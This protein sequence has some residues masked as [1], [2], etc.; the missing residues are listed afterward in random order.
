[1]NDVEMRRWLAGL[2][3]VEN[4]AASALRKSLKPV[5][6]SVV[7]YARQQ[8]QAASAR[9][10]PVIAIALDLPRISQEVQSRFTQSAGETEMAEAATAAYL[11]GTRE[12]RKRVSRVIE[13]KAPPVP[14]D[15]VAVGRRTERDKAAA[16]AR[17]WQDEN[18][19]AAARAVTRGLVSDVATSTRMLEIG[20]AAALSYRSLYAARN[21]TVASA[22]VGLFAAYGYAGMTGWEWQAEDDACPICEG[23]N[24][25]VF[26][27]GEPFEAPHPNCRCSA[28]P[29]Q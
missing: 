10:D 27:A 4:A 3:R 1:M 8:A 12:G 23:L 13:A 16:Y 15:A 11:F 28:L 17:A 24:G 19:R 25:E 14:T 20:L 22:R 5:E 26:S 21:V 18:G 6:E 7:K 29:V 2:G 9:D